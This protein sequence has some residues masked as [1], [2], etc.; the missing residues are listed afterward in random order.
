MNQD[1][2]AS[3]VSEGVV[4]HEELALVMTIKQ[5]TQNL[6]RASYWYPTCPSYCWIKPTF[7]QRAEEIAY[8]PLTDGE[9]LQVD[10]T[11]YLGLMASSEPLP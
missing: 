6:C 7:F 10:S 9:L 3:T 4:T 1:Y 5:R 8:S 11:G 2:W